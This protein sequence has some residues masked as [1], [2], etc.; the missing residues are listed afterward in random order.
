MSLIGAGSGS[1]SPIL[2][3]ASESDNLSP[4]KVNVSLLALPM[5]VTFAMKTTMHMNRVYLM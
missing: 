1:S 4:A 3:T 2:T 5:T